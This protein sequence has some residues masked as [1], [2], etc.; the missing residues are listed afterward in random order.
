[1]IHTSPIFSG[2]ISMSGSLLVNGNDLSNGA[3]PIDGTVS[4][5]KLAAEFNA[6]SSLTAGASVD[7]DCSSAQVFSLTPNQNT[8]LNITNPRVGSTKLILVTGAGGSSGA[9]DFSGITWTSWSATNSTGSPAN[10]LVLVTSGFDWSSHVGNAS[11][12]FSFGTI[13][14]NGNVNINGADITAGDS[15]GV[16]MSFSFIITSGVTSGTPGDLSG[17]PTGTGQSSYGLSFTVGGS[18]GTF[19]QVAGTYN[20]T[21]SAKNFIQLT[22]VSPTEF[23]YTISQIAS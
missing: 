9:L 22:C 4:N 19:N 6:T 11:S 16:T 3:T 21:S 23:W 17:G 20:D 10:K 2:S 1:M 13:G 15:T 12:D 5:A 8:T 18:S 14:N 7:V